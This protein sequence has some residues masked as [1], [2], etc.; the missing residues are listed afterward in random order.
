[1]LFT[2]IRNDTEPDNNY[3]RVLDPRAS[4]ISFV[5]TSCLKRQALYLQCGDLQCGV[6]S[7]VNNQKGDINL[8][9]MATPGDW[10]WHVSLFRSE[11]HV[12]DGTLVSR[13]TDLPKLIVENKVYF[14]CS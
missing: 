2:K 7:A 5:R 10:P 3:V 11:T 6:Q 9:K 8:S 4:E 13:Q 1:V 14:P 12:C